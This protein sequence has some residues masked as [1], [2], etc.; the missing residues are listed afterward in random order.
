[1][2][3]TALF[4]SFLALPIVAYALP[5]PFAFDDGKWTATKYEKTGPADDGTWTATK[6]EPTTSSVT[7]TTSTAT[8]TPA[9]NFTIPVPPNS[10]SL[11]GKTISI[12]SF[13]FGFIVNGTNT[14]HTSIPIT[15]DTPFICGSSDTD[16]CSIGDL[17]IDVCS[18]KE[19]SPEQFAQIQCRTSTVKHPEL[20]VAFNSLNIQP[21]VV[22]GTGNTKT[23][24][25]LECRVMPEGQNLIEEID[26]I[27]LIKPS[28][29]GFCSQ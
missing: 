2:H 18:N 23:L 25:V 9:V 5:R 24:E 3:S 19:I 17:A 11:A 29:Q 26:G 4:A 12:A 16:N 15:L 20:F 22:P 6:Y 13:P 14:K 7:A 21:F 1:M 8:A 10:G 27:D 28:G